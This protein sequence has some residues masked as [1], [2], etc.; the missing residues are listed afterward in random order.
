MLAAK[1][2]NQK[3][4]PNQKRRIPNIEATF[5]PGPNLGLGLRRMHCDSVRATV[6][7]LP[8]WE[9]ITDNYLDLGG[10]DRKTLEEIR[11]DSPITLHG[12]G[13]SIGSMDPINFTYLKQVKDLMDLVQPMAVS[14]HL[15]W[16]SIDGRYFHDLL[17]LPYTQEVLDRLVS[18]IIEIQEF[19]GRSLTLENVS[20]YIRFKADSWSEWDFVSELV[21][22]TDCRIL[23]DVN[24]IF[25]NSVNFAFSADKYI[26]GIP[27]HAVQQ[28][29]IAGAKKIDDFYLDDH[30]SAP[31][32]EVINLL[33]KALAR[34]GSSTPVVLEWDNNLPDFPSLMAERERILTCLI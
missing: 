13:L 17:P 4:M 11:T 21:R 1:S 15:S 10:Q 29:H 9:L 14:D 34:F 32:A 18:K 24:N 31:S 28:I 20:S 22:R 27:S 7:K 5:L 12:V 30:G 6:P 33:Q 2:L 3:Q 16:G 25:V 19:L 23:L 8:F 26:E